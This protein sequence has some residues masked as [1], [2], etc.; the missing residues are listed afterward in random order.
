MKKLLLVL[1]IAMIAALAV[2]AQS[3]CGN[4]WI[5]GTSYTFDPEGCGGDSCFLVS[6]IVQCDYA[7]CGYVTSYCDCGG[8]P[9]RGILSA[10]CV[11]F[12]TDKARNDVIWKQKIASANTL[13]KAGRSGN[14]GR[15]LYSLR[16]AFLR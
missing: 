7:P 6:I 13:L 16:V 8:P 3:D 15:N 11:K 9:I 10:K 12:R 14:A 1:F 2:N 5:A 4:C